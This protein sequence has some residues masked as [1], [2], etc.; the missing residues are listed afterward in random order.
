MNVLYAKDNRLE[1]EQQEQT[2]VRMK[3]TFPSF[4]FLPTH[5]ETPIIHPQMMTNVWEKYIR[6]SDNYYTLIFTIMLL[7][8]LKRSGRKKCEN[9][10]QDF[11]WLPLCD[12]QFL[13][14]LHT[15]F[16]SPFHREFASCMVREDFWQSG[17]VSKVKCG[18]C[19]RGCGE[20]DHG[21]S[22]ID[23][24]VP[25]RAIAAVNW[26]Q[27]IYGEKVKECWPLSP[28]NLYRKV[29]LYIAQHYMFYD[30]TPLILLIAYM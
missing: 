1:S 13:T 14:F 27:S 4:C 26:K 17:R 3:N 29:V 20:K 21:K 22:H 2:S 16:P 6:T 12:S 11:Y 30:A 28:C 10:W 18:G 24:Y 8:S 25:T 19:W 7:T 15:T 5:K 9:Y 23:V